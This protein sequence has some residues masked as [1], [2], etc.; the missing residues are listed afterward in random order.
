MGNL[1]MHLGFNMAAPMWL[2]ILLFLVFGCP[3]TSQ[4][5]R[6]CQWPQV[7]EHGGFRCASS[8]SMLAG[9]KALSGTLVEYYCESGYMFSGQ[10]RISVCR[11]GKW[12]MNNRVSCQAV[13]GPSVHSTT[14][15]V[16][17]VSSFPIMA[18]VAITVSSLLLTATVCVLLRPKPCCS[19]GGSNYQRMEEPNVLIVNGQPVLLP[20]YEEAVYGPQGNENPLNSPSEAPTSL[21]Q[22]EGQIPANLGTAS[23]VTNQNAGTLTPPPSYEEVQSS[24]WLPPTGPEQDEMRLPPQYFLFNIPTTK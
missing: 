16:P 23:H 12:T 13:A 18:V 17:T 20:S 7:P 5:I 22:E 14:R 15:T 11:K 2:V 19:Q 3:S 4:K 21:I 6:D 1:Q 24:T 8:C 10:S 9:G